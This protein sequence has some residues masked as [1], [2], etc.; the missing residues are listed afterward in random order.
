MHTRSNHYATAFT[1]SRRH[2]IRCARLMLAKSAR[3]ALVLCPIPGHPSLQ[4]ACTCNVSLTA[5]TTVATQRL[6]QRHA[7]P[8]HKNR[9]VSH[10]YSSKSLSWM[11]TPIGCVRLSICFNVCVSSSA[12]P[13]LQEIFLFS[14]NS[15]QPRNHATPHDQPPSFGARMPAG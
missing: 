9:A 3:L 13:A 7:L 10:R 5:P 4:S 12:E 1:W 15:C 8:C 2:E 11:T 6:D 14:A